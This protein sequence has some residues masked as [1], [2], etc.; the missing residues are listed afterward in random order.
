A[1]QRVSALLAAHRDLLLDRDAAGPGMRVDV[2]LRAGRQ[3]NGDRAGAALHVPRTRGRAFGR[4]VAASGPR[5]QLA[6]DAG[7]LDASRA[8]GDVDP[9]RAAVRQ[10]DRAAAGPRGERR[11]DPASD[12]RAA[13]GPKSHFA[14]DSVD[15]DVSRARRGRDAAREPR[16]GLAAGARARR[17]GRL[18]RH[19]AVVADRHAAAKLLVVDAADVDAASRD[20][21]RRVGLDAVDERLRLGLVAQEA[22][23]HRDA[24]VDANLAGRALTNVDRAAAGHDVERDRL[25]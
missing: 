17:C 7:E 19:D 5:A 23:A 16:Q 24:A 1:A 21:D 18:G 20:R 13:A 2:E 6:F 4:D 22:S 3:P 8:R 15:V 10:A 9:G 11:V 14:A 12:D 25:V